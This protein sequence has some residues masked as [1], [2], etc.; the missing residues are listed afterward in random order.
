[1]NASM[2]HPNQSIDVSWMGAR[3]HLQ[4]SSPIIKGTL[5]FLVVIDYLSKWSEVIPLKNMIHKEVI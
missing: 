1:V 2:L 5:F 3:P 4:N